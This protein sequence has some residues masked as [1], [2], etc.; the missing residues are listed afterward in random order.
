MVNNS[1]VHQGYTTISRE[2]ASDKQIEIRVFSSITSRMKA[3][4]PTKIGGFAQ[5][6]EAMQDNTRLWNILFTDV[7]D[8]NNQLPKALKAQLIN[9]AEFTRQH[10]LK[11][12]QGEGSI[13]ALID[14]N[15]A[16]ING[17]RGNLPEMEAA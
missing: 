9:L 2:T 4:D 13:D 6:A 7:I 1:R 11:V 16:V 14:I 17:L 8:E 12:L 3:A 10:T 5:M 15:Q